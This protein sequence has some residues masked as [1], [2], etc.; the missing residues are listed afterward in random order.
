MSSARTVRRARLKD[1]KKLATKMRAAAERGDAATW[2]SLLGEAQ[3]RGHIT[4]EQVRQLHEQRE[5]LRAELAK[6]GTL[7][8]IA[9]RIG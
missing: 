4:P 1:Q 2:D 6:R 8:P 9:G 3:R 5:Y 7:P